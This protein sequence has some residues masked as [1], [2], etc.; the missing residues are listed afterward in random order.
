MAPTRHGR[1]E[2]APGRGRRTERGVGGTPESGSRGYQLGVDKNVSV[3]IYIY[4]YSDNNNSNNNNS[5]FV[6]CY[7]LYFI[8]Y[9]YICVCVH[10][11]M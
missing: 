10:L 9:I 1:P 11:C 7:I 4:M 6:I 5:I 8:L 2:P 3:Y